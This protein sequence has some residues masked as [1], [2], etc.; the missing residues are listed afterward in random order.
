MVLILQLS[1][2]ELASTLQILFSNKAAVGALS[3][4]LHGGASVLTLEM[5]DKVKQS[6]DVAEFVRE[7]LRSGGK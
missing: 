4:S 5:L 2:Q 7:L 6:G 1:Q 3:G